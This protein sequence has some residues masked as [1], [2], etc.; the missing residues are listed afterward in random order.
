MGFRLSFWEEKAHVFSHILP[1][2]LSVF[3]SI[4]IS[5]SICHCY[6]VFGFYHTEFVLI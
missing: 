1:N 5:C 2:E 3:T 6:K 4:Y